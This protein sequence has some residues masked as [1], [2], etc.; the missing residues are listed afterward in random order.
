MIIDLF[1]DAETLLGKEE[2]NLKRAALKIAGLNLEIK[3]KVITRFRI[4]EKG[5]RGYP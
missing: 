4:S 5:D 2:A 3:P 1:P